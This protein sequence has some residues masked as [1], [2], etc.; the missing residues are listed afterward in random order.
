MRTT[1]KQSV[2]AILPALFLAIFLAG[3]R[4]AAAQEKG[5][6]ASVAGHIPRPAPET[7]RP[8]AV[9]TRR[10]IELSGAQNVRDLLL[11]RVVFNSF[12]LYRP[13]VAGAGR[14][15]FLINGR[16][17][18]YAG[19]DAEAFPL[20]AVERIEILSDNAAS[21]HGG[22]AVG[23]AINIVLRR[24]FKG[25][26]VGAGAARPGQ[27]GGDSE[28]GSFV[29]G[30][31]LGRGRVVVGLDVV[32]REEI[33][34]ADRE[35]SR[36]SWT[37]GGS[38]ADSREISVGGNTAFITPPG[39]STIARP[40]G[41]CEGSGYVAGLTNPRNHPGVGCGFDYTAV[42]WHDGWERLAREGLFLSAEHPLGESAD[43]YLD[44]RAAR[45][46]S[47][48]RYAP[49][50]GTFAFAPP[51][52]LREK[53][54]QDP[55]I[56]ALPDE[57]IVAHRF[58]G[59]GNREWVTDVEERDVTLG[60]RGKLGEVGYDAHVRYYLHDAVV[61]GNTFVSESAIAGVIG[62]GRYDVENPFSTDSDHLAAVRETSLVLEHEQV[63]EYTAARVSF[64][65]KAFPLPGGNVLW[66]VGAEVA[67]QD[68]KSIHDYRDMNRRSYDP[69]DVLGS[70]GSSSVGDRQT[71]SAFAEV[72]L[73]LIKGWDVTLAGRHDDHD[74][75][76]ATFSGQVASRYRPNKNL[77]LR[78]SW[79]TGGKPPDLSVLGLR[80]QSIDYPYVCDVTTHT[81]DIVD[82]DRTQ[83]ERLSS[84]NPE[85]EPD[86]AK[87]LG[88]GAAAS[89]GP[90][91]LS[92]DWFRINLSEVPTRWLAQHIID[93]ETKGQ[94][95]AGERVVRD[96]NLLRRI[97]GSWANIG[98]TDVEGVDLRARLDW[99]T[100]FGDVAFDMRW[101]R[102]TED[103]TRAAGQ[104]VPGDYPRDRVHVSMRARRG[105]VTA[106]WSVYGVSGYWNTDRTARYGQWAGHDVTLRWREAFGFRELEL[107]GGVL[108]IAD[109]GPSIADDVPDLTF[110]SAQGRT[111]FLNAKYTFGP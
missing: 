81:G 93:L 57:I 103:E 7:P 29:W 62:D 19:F 88:I 41:A 102:V 28:Q 13:F 69:T 44:A 43:V 94:L 89:L 36:G 64:N 59:H 38:F 91:S 50:V 3:A 76:G 63:A 32:R 107:I 21:I 8:V 17:A 22:H 98:E 105:S 65:G 73:P 49:S 26:E 95:P 12:G 30:G 68:W 51:Q 6:G 72:S 40:L 71:F 24:D 111:L 11:S 54:L 97:E 9:I 70:G 104:K 96:G 66:A 83:V 10:D 20:S 47:R 61:N 92:L 109:R 15:V 14:L 37:P 34:D 106:N 48:S 52:S 78:A 2:H 31:A 85:L 75:V 60:L 46:E 16:R 82:C 55:E 25:I 23:G 53:L 18:S 77:A 56:D 101:S 108:N 80:G 86:E 84:G 100:D 110:A 4:D 90:F 87:S 67:S 1:R 5:A 58:V 33:R 27:A 99:K 35:Y 42:K 74:D 39:G 79:G 45:S